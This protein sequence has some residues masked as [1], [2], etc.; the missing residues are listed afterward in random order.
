M[1]TLSKI[2]QQYPDDGFI[3]A[4]GFDDA[5]I[6][7]WSQGRLVYSIDKIIEILQKDMTEDEAISFYESASDEAVLNKV[8][9]F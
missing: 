4:E 5:L 2:L 7:V 1:S 9:G 8:T 3:T 6:G